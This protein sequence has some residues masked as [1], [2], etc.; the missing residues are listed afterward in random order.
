MEHDDGVVILGVVV[1]AV[2]GAV[3][4]VGLLL[5]FTQGPEP[6]AASPVSVLEDAQFWVGRRLGRAAQRHIVTAVYQN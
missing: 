3:S 5:Y 6:A 4:I 1:A 2:V